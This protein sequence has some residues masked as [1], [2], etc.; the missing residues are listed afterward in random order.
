MLDLIQNMGAEH[1]YAKD[2]SEEEEMFLAQKGAITSIRET[3]GNKEITT[4]RE[5]QKENN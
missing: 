5:G 3:S 4:Y 1:K 2:I